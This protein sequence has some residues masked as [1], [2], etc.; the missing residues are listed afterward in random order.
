MANTYWFTSLA[1]TVGVSEVISLVINM[2]CGSYWGA[3]ISVT[4]YS[5]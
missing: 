3:L 2:D 4:D 1:F 5:P